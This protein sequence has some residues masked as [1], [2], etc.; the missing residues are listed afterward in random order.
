MN[1]ALLSH[2]NLH[3]FALLYWLHLFVLSLSRSD[4]TDLT[5]QRTFQFPSQQKAE[6]QTQRW[7]LELTCD[8]GDNQMQFDTNLW[9]TR[10]TCGRGQRVVFNLKFLSQMA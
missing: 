2:A 3:L 9:R 7:G 5:I 10:T 6:W 8:G 4:S 1:H